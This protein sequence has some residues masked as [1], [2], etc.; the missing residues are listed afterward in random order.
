MR[1]QT[2][3]LAAIALWLVIAGCVPESSRYIRATDSTETIRLACVGD[4]ITYGAGIQDRE[5]NHYP[6]QL[7]KM[8]GNGWNTANFG[9]SGATLLQNGDK[10]YRMEGA[11]RGALAFNPHV[12]IIMLGTNDTKPQ[13]WKYND[14]FIDDYKELIKDFAALPTRPRIWVC[15]PAPAFLERWGISDE[16]IRE[17]IIPR[18][19]RVAKEMG[20]GLIDLN[21]PLQGRG[22]LFSDKIHPTAKG[23]GV[24]AREIFQAIT[25]KKQTAFFPGE[26]SLWHGFV[27]HD[28]EYD[29][30]KCIV[31]LPKDAHRQKPWIWRARFFGHE[32]QTDLALLSK[33]FFLVYIDVARLYGN[34]RAVGHWDAFYEYLT[35]E[36]GF[37]KKAA[38]EGMS[39]GGLIIYNWAAA[40]PEKVACIYA[41]A[42]VCD[43]SSWPGGKGSGQS[44]EKNWQQC[45]EAYGLKDDLTDADQ[46][47]EFKGNP[48]DKLEP[49]AGAEIP[50]L[51]ICGQVDQIVPPSENTDV[52]AKRYKALGGSIRVI[53]KKGVGH[54]PHSMTEPGVIVNFILQHTIGDS[55]HVAVRNDM[56]ASLEQFANKKRG[57]VAFIG[58]SI[59]KMEGYRPMVCAAMKEM[60][61]DTRF[62]FIN[63]G[64]S[65]TC[66]TTGAFRLAEHVLSSGSVD[67]LFVEFAVNDNQDA[68]HSRQECIRGMEGIV[69]RA[70]DENPNMDIVF[71]Y[72]ANEE[73]IRA[74]QAGEMPHEIAAHEEV[75]RYYGLCSINLAGD[76]AERIKAGEFDW[77]RFGGTHPGPLGNSLYAEDIKSLF[78]TVWDN[79]NDGNGII[80]SGSSGN[81]DSTKAIAYS[82]PA[83]PLD[84]FSYGSGRMVGIVGAKIV[85]G[86]RIEVPQW[87]QLKGTTRQ[88]FGRVAMLVAE[89]PEAELSLQFEGTAVGIFVVAGPDAGIVEYSIDGGAFRQADLYHR[90]SAGLH[91]PRTIMFDDELANDKHKLLLRMT[92]RKNPASTGTSV[93]IVNFVVN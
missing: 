14:D 6:L 2:I 73:Y 71:L 44:N 51:H 12:V 18:V 19:R 88:R 26:V 33:G 52:L 10:P 53:H 25:G 78:K 32:P 34:N 59:T 86:W 76:V 61:P 57:R 58:G 82:T 45:M 5:N 83:K 8:L 64:I 42:P 93:R 54:H 48:I 46:A 85:N 47:D 40:N 67:L 36:H 80:S 13:N 41:D 56:Q 31:V 79:N 16:V 37:A 77:D 7:G 90:F 91:Y 22:E 66:S 23:A 21:T 1:H 87:S 50:L 38:L 65:S 39:R 43:I 74:F 72:T 89:Q 28:F 24:M 60:F 49:I 15:L 81:D 62:D 55:D 27:R 9:V 30:Q 29:G 11:Y 75:A 63:A 84:R 69:R 3:R 17:G 70:R 35:K 20:V 68:A 92:N 4:S